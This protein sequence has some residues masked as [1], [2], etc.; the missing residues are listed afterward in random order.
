MS[1][2]RIYFKKNITRQVEHLRRVKEQTKD[3]AKAFPVLFSDA[4][5][6]MYNYNGTGRK[7]RRPMKEYHVFH[8]CMLG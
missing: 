7:E 1:K 8:D 6:E 5:L 4:A 3:V 2:K